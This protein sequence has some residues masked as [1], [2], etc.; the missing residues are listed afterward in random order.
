MS[1]I[2]FPTH[3]TPR[4]VETSRRGVSWLGFF[5]AGNIVGAVA[6]LSM[7]VLA[8]LL[9]GLASVIRQLTNIATNVYD[10]YIGVPL[11]VEEWLRRARDD[12]AAAPMLPRTL[13]PSEGE[14][15]AREGSLA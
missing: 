15:R 4:W 14:P 8:G 2:R 10:V 1:S 11:R 3:S 5:Y 7:K 13:A 9:V 12:D 6:E